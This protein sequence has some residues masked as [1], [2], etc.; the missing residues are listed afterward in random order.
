MLDG[1]HPIR[2]M[3]HIV[4]YDYQETTINTEIRLTINFIQF[5]HQVDST[6]FSVPKVINASAIN[7]HVRHFHSIEGMELKFHACAKFLGLINYLILRGIS[8]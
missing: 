6:T 1:I 7:A 4:F 3:H 2:N 8:M 5:S